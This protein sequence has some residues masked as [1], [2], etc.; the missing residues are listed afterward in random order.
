M[1]FKEHAG[2][3]LTS[4]KNS[5]PLA[6]RLITYSATAGA[7]LLTAPVADA[8]VQ[9]INGLSLSLDLPE[10]GG[11]QSLTINAG[12]FHGELHGSRGTNKMMSFAPGTYFPGSPPYTGPHGTYY[13]G[14]PGFYNPGHSFTVGTN[15]HGR[16]S[17]LGNIAGNLASRLDKG[18][19]FAGL[20]FSNNSHPLATRTN[21]GSGNGNFRT[22]SGYVAFQTGSYYGW[23]KIKV[24]SDSN[25]APS[26]ISLVDNGDGIYGAYDKISDTLADN[27][28]VGAIAAP[29]PSL[30]A[31]GG[32]GL[33]AFGAA[34]VR[35]LR[36]RKA[37]APK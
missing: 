4:Q 13:A 30:A 35:E 11:F 16:A 2:K 9:N 7:A 31:I 18:I 27:F 15:H 28:T 34:G 10:N 8:A 14:S 5:E 25:G 22:R 36:R 24:D 12:P 3:K 6:R 19:Q 29:E 33:L 20:N 32:L 1:K 23:L 37:A 17:I 21:Y 26:H